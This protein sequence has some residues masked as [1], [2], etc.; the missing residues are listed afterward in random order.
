MNGHTF[1]TAEMITDLKA[2]KAV[3]ALIDADIPAYSCGFS[4]ENELSWSLVE[5]TV[6][7]F[8]MKVIRESGATHMIGFLTKGSTNFRLE[9]AK[10]YVYKGNRAGT[11]RPKWYTKIR[12]YLV[13]HWNCQIMD[14]IE[15][16]DALAISQEYLEAQGI[17]SVICS[18]DK[19]LR[20][21]T[22]WHYNWDSGILD[23]VDAEKAHY[24]LWK[25]MITGD[26]GTDNIP[27]LSE[28]AWAPKVGSRVPVFNSEMRI[29]HEPKILKSGKPST[30]KMAHAV[31]SHW[32]VLE[33]TT[34][35]KATADQYYGD[36][37]ARAI[38]AE[39]EPEAYPSVVLTEYVDAYWED[40][41]IQELDDPAEK[42]ISRFE[43]VFRLIYMLRTVDE[44]PN[45]AVIDFTPVRCTLHVFNDFDE[46]DTDALDEFDDF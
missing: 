36:T 8:M 40:G 19:D 42:G 38:L 27:G 41:E 3:V 26:L 24:N 39:C 13:N 32:E 44:I 43:E 6:D 45:D 37:R 23:F 9:D 11:E 17:K 12:E 30:R 14:G 31:F 28:A 16:D 29:P 46:E 33:T 18:L 22:G 7:N 2:E 25:Q 4:C 10:T 1:L 20:Q 21:V 34:Q 35:C 5:K 15:A